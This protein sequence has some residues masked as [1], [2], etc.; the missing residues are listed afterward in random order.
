MTMQEEAGYRADAREAR[1]AGTTEKQVPT[2]SIYKMKGKPIIELV[3]T[4]TDAQA[5]AALEA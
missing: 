3:A 2:E 1:L 4:Q 5:L